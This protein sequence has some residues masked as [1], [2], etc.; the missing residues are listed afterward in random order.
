[1]G[2]NVC[3]KRISRY[4]E[5]NMLENLEARKLEF[6]VVGDFLT[7]LKKEFSSGNNK[8]IKIVEIK[9][10]EQRSRTIEEFVQKFR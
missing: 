10:V 7:K 5:G 3:A 9:K 2:S 1:M 6:S 4:L 8:L